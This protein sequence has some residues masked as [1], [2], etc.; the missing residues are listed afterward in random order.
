MASGTFSAKATRSLPTMITRT[1]CGNGAPDACRKIGSTYS[2]PFSPSGSTS[3]LPRI[4]DEPDRSQRLNWA[5]MASSWSMSDSTR[6][7]PSVE[8]SFGKWN[9]MRSPY[10][11]GSMRAAV[12]AIMFGRCSGT[13]GWIRTNSA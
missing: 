4:T 1:N 8:V 7:G 5:L 11:P 6:A 9:A 13:S 3:R 12:Q 10:T 2:S